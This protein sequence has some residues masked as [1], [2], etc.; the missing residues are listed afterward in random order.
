MGQAPGEEFGCYAVK[1]RCFAGRV[2]KH[3]VL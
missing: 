1:P 3:T 2:Y